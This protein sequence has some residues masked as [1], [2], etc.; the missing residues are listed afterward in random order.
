MGEDWQ[1]KFAEADCY[2]VCGSVVAQQGTVLAGG[3]IA[4]GA[5][6]GL[7]NYPSTREPVRA[8]HAG[9]ILALC[10]DTRHDSTI[11]AIA[12]TAPR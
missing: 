10:Y 6:L 7:A 5:M 1:P 12:S 8:L 9:H 4:A 3:A 11:V 2:E